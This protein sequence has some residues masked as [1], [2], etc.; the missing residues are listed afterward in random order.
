MAIVIRYA[1]RV[2]R[3]HGIFIGSGV[4]YWSDDNSRRRR[5]RLERNNR[6][7]PDS[8]DIVMERC[9]SL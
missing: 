9:L 5:L 7:V 4:Y 2:C 8:Q 3:R 6:F 1:C